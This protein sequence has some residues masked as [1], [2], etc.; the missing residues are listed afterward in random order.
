MK[1]NEKSAQVSAQVTNASANAQ[2]T[3]NAPAQE[4]PL[5]KDEYFTTSEYYAGW[6]LIKEIQKESLPAAI[7]A[8]RAIIKT[9]DEA[10][11]LYHLFALIPKDLP[12][13]LLAKCEKAINKRYK[14]GKPAKSYSV[15][16]IW[17]FWH[18]YAVEALK[19]TTD[20]E[21]ANVRRMHAKKYL[22][23]QRMLKQ[24]KKAAKQ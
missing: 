18:K 22:Q 24:N 16:Y 2:V 20:N 7:R 4:N 13:D 15:F 17:Q 14:D 9:D 8:F 11:P 23:V 5:A 3:N 1:K 12:K 10:S 21:E 6:K 19:D